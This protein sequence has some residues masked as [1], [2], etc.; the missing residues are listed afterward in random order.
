MDQNLRFVFKCLNIFDYFLTVEE[1]DDIGE[2]HVVVD[3]N[4]AVIF[5]QCEGD[6]QDKAARAGM[7]SAP[8]RLPDSEHIAVA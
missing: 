6:E 1:A 5:D 4:L 3:D 7:L 2:V 8:D